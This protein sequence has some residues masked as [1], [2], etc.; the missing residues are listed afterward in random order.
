MTTRTFK[1]L[2]FAR[3]LFVALAMG[4]VMSRGQAYVEV[5]NQGAIRRVDVQR[6][7]TRTADGELVLFRENKDPLTVKPG[8]YRRAVGVKPPELDR[9]VQQIN[10]GN[11]QEGAK[12]LRQAMRKSRFQSWDVRAGLM[13]MDLLV[14]MGENAAATSVLNQLRQTYGDEMMELYPGTQLGDWKVRIAT[15]S[16]A[17]LQE[18]LTEVIQDAETP[19]PKKAM[20]QM[21]RGDL[22]IRREEFQS[23]ALDFLRAAYFFPDVKEVHAEALYKTANTFAKLGDAVRSRKYQQRLKK[24]HPDSTFAGKSI[25]N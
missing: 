19:R 14:E 18:E 21:V 8:Q 2:I 13:L 15:G 17:G 24:L 4:A 5:E 3:T 16:V 20:A 9:A 7:A 10:S 23:A 22:K 6:I 11:K 1:R 12:L 25:G